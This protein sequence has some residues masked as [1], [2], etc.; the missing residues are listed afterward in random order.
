MGAVVWKLYGEES[1]AGDALMQRNFKVEEPRGK[2]VR[3]RDKDSEDGISMQ[4]SPSPPPPPSSVP[5]DLYS[6]LIFCAIA[7]PSTPSSRILISPLHLKH[8]TPL[9]ASSHGGG[10]RGVTTSSRNHL[11]RR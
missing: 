6:G 5:S 9:T 10:G 11:L 2:G 1:S 3:E 7:S 8:A 4:P